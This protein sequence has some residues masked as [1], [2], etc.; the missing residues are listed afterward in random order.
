MTDYFENFYACLFLHLK[1]DHISIRR[2]LLS[3]CPAMHWAAAGAE[4]CSWSSVYVMRWEPAACAA[5]TA[6]ASEPL[7]A[8]KEQ[9]HPSHLWAMRY[10]HSGPSQ[11]Q[12]IH[13]LKHWSVKFSYTYIYSLKELWAIKGKWLRINKIL[14]WAGSSVSYI[15]FFSKYKVRHINLK[16]S[17]GKTW[18]IQSRL[19]LCPRL[20]FWCSV[21]LRT[22]PQCV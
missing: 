12:G 13:N 2:S 4:L 18:E 19:L 3:L 7:K 8:P 9:L 14:F 11:L 1:L 5:G 22:S 16:Y 6:S 17:T 21:I 10:L 20:A 15:F